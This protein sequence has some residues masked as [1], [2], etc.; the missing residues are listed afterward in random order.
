MS[1]EFNLDLL[2][3]DV[4]LKAGISSLTPSDCKKLSLLVSRSVNKNISETTLKRLFGFANAKHNFSK[5]TI[6]ALCEFVGKERWEKISSVNG[7]TPELASD[8]WDEMKAVAEKISKTTLMAVKNRSGIPFECTVPREF[9]ERDFEEF[10]SSDSC[11]TGLVS[12]SASGKSI[13]LAHLLDKMFLSEGAP[14]SNDML[15]FVTPSTLHSPDFFNI[16]E[17]LN[18]QLGGGVSF[19]DYFRGKPEQIKGKVFIVMDGVDN[20]LTK[21]DFRSQFNY[22]TDF[23]C[24]LE[25]VSWV[26]LIFSMRSISWSEFHENIRR[27]AFLKSKWFPGNYFV[28]GDFSN[29][30]HLTDKE[31]CK[32]LKGLPR[33]DVD[34]ITPKL[35]SQFKFPFYIQTFYQ[36]ILENESFNY[37]SDLT[38]YELINAFIHQ[39]INLSPKYTEKILLLKKIIQ[40][41]QEG[42]KIN[43]V[44]KQDLLGDITTF[45]EAY[46]EL[47][48][49]GILVEEKH[50]GMVMPREVIRF[51]HQPIFE[52]FLFIEIIDGNHQFTDLNVFQYINKEYQGLPIRQQLFRWGIR[53][54]V[55]NHD[56]NAL[57]GIL[58]LNVPEDEKSLL[59]LCVMETVEYKSTLKKNLAEKVLD[60][61]LHQ[62][63][64]EILLRFNIFNPCYK[65]TLQILAKLT[66]DPEYLVIYQALLAYMAVQELNKQEL[67]ASVKVLSEI[68]YDRDQWLFQPCEIF[69]SVL[70]KLSSSTG[71]DFPVLSKVEQ[72]SRCPSQFEK[73][74]ATLSPQVLISYVIS[75]ALGFFYAGLGNI[76]LLYKS[77]KALHPT[78]QFRRACLSVLLLNF[79]ALA[80]LN[81]YEDALPNKLTGLLAKA[82]KRKGEGSSIHLSILYYLMR[83]KQHLLK[84][85]LQEAKR[86]AEKCLLLCDSAGLGLLTVILRNSL[87]KIYKNLGEIDKGEEALYNLH[88]LLDKK[89]I[90]AH[91]FIS[92]RKEDNSLPMF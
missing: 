43:Q 84:V 81:N 72:F 9:A 75:S 26:K 3:K 78:I 39:K 52:Y 17:W 31:I 12:P 90:A 60:E 16:N 20:F 34:K 42:R 53:N 80:S 38:F 32:I 58:H 5:F 79:T 66:I 82:E 40:L 70:F 73:S 24:L 33:I 7:V 23:I 92:N 71:R 62:T 63:I 91:H 11:F 49:D 28:A 18:E 74:Y 22:F 36:L 15:W 83:V 25:G 2:R 47:L 21:K 67:A 35:K 68:S 86:L 44:Y 10:Y 27:S 45:K 76:S 61:R 56:V 30:P 54:A 46:E 37:H 59:L 8:R 1:Y 19:I 48:L 55:K 50:M 6:T 88:S 77:I 64:V 51:I 87:A 89:G 13:L 41:A 29:V 65:K 57:I 85:E 69:E 4:L 14:K